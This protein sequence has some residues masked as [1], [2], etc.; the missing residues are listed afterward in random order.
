MSKKRSRAR[1]YAVQALYQ[2]QMTDYAIATVI[3][4]FVVEKN[5]KTYEREY[6]EE[7]VRGTITGLADIDAALN[8]LLDRDIEKVDLIERAILRLA[9]YELQSH[10]EIPYRVI[11]NEAVELAKTYGAEMGH[12]YVNGVVDKLSRSVRS[13]EFKAHRQSR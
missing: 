6:F 7:L 2:W 1:E 13:I 8:P 5:P 9:T 4:Q 12:K 10:P 11:I 3:Q